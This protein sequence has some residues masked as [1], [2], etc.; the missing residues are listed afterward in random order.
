[1]F[2]TSLCLRWQVNRAAQ[3]G[4]HMVPAGGGDGKPPICNVNI[5]QILNTNRS[6]DVEHLFREVCE[7]KFAHILSL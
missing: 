7:I 1:M 4:V 2:R 3:G 6:F 5:K